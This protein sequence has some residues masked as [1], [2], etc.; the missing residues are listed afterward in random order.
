VAR[1]GQDDYRKEWDFNE[2]D[3]LFCAAMEEEAPDGF[4]AVADAYAWQMTGEPGVA[5]DQQGTTA[6]SPP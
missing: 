3:C 5:P 4:L 6:I 2:L 1:Q